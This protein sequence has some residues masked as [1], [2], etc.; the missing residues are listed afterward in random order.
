M[1][2]KR[3]SAKSH[4]MKILHLLCHGKCC[5]LRSPVTT[6]PTYS[7]IDCNLTWRDV[8]RRRLGVSKVGFGYRNTLKCLTMVEY[9][10]MSERLVF[11]DSNARGNDV[12]C[13]YHSE[14]SRILYE[15]AVSE[16]LRPC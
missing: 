16:H 4:C 1:S 13:V 15:D 11:P 6:S 8:K 9:T 14:E 7:L 3:L 12:T 2:G 5:Q 10:E